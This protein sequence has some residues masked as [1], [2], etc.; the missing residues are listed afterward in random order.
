MADR[1]RAAAALQAIW[2]PSALVGVNV[3][4]PARASIPTRP[5]TLCISTE[6][7]PRS[8]AIPELVVKVPASAIPGNVT[9]TRS[10]VTRTR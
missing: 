7:T 2:P 9:V 6:P 10:A 4:P 5:P 3:T 8:A 1:R